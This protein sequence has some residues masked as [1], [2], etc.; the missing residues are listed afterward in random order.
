MSLIKM[1]YL[2]PNTKRRGFEEII[3]NLQHDWIGREATATT[4]LK[5][6]Q[7]VNLTGRFQLV[8]IDGIVPAFD[9]NGTFVTAHP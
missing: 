5:I 3:R 7:G 6:A 2:G 4:L 1:L 8:P 9:V